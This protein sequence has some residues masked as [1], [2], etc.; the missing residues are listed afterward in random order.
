MSI[1]S[2]LDKYVYYFLWHIY[3]SHLWNP[4]FKHDFLTSTRQTCSKTHLL[5]SLKY[6]FSGEETPGPPALNTA[7]YNVQGKGEFNTASKVEWAEKWNTAVV[8]LALH[9]EWRASGGQDWSQLLPESNTGACSGQA[10]SIS[11][12]RR[13]RSTAA[14]RER[15]NDRE[16]SPGD[17][18]PGGR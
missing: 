4:A 1:L 17:T 14:E 18:V 2:I 6:K 3:T 7:A 13:M 8:N 12:A 10:A 9:F 16:R 15:Q 11:V 5:A